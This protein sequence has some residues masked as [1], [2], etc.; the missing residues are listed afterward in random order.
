MPTRLLGLHHHHLVAA[1]KTY[2]NVLVR[3]ILFGLH[4]RDLVR[5]ARGTLNFVRVP[6]VHKELQITNVDQAIVRP[7]VLARMDQPL[8]LILGGEDEAVV[9]VVAVEVTMEVVVV[10][11]ATTKVTEEPKV[12]EDVDVEDVVAEE[13]AVDVVVEEVAVEDVVVEENKKNI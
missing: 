4:L 13:V 5:T 7:N 6:M 3:T 10:L 8:C 11:E 12:V 1:R 2:R 9:A